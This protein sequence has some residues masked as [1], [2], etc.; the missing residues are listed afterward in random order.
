MSVLKTIIIGNLGKDATINN[1]NGQNCI[2]FSVAH[3]EK[4]KDSQGVQKE[5]TTWVSCSF[6]SDRTGIVPYLTKGSSVYVEG[7]PEARVYTNN[8]GESVATLQLRVFDIKLL[9]GHKKENTTNN[10]GSDIPQGASDMP[11]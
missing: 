3:S 7:Q 8:R 11:F 1:V 5:K 6:W 9:G 10:N 2:V 4:W